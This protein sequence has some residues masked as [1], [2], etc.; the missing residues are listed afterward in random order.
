M[1]IHY[2]TL[3]GGCVVK[4]LHHKP[5]GFVLKSTWLTPFGF[6]HRSEATLLLTPGYLVITTQPKHQAILNA[7]NE[8]QLRQDEVREDFTGAIETLVATFKA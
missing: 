2:H 3:P 4:Q 1:T 8:L 7:I 6:D 5:R